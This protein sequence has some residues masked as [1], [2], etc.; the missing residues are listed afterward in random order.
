EQPVPVVWN[1]CRFGGARPYFVCP[2]V[3][4]GVAC[5]LRVTKLCLAGT[6]FLCRCCYGLAYASQRE[7]R[8]GRALRRASKIRMRL[9]GEADI[10]SAFP[11]RPKGMH[12]QTYERLQSAALNAEIL[13]EEGLAIA[14]APLVGVD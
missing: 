3:V 1:A 4:N 5:G 13:A 7:D 12:R 14:I 6:Y 2:G 8:Y 10:V 11:A 9:G